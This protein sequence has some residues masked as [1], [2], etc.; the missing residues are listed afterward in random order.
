MKF[1]E[2]PGISRAFRQLPRLHA[3]RLDLGDTISLGESFNRRAPRSRPFRC[4]DQQRR[5]RPFRTRRNFFRR[6]PCR[7]SFKQSSSRNR[8]LPARL[9]LDADTRQRTHH[10]CHIAGL[11]VCRFH[12]WPPTT[13]R[14]PRWLRSPCRCN[15]SSKDRTFASSICSP[16]D[17]CTDF[18]DAIARTDGGDPR[19]TG[20]SRAGLAR[21][22]P[23]HESRAQA[24]IGRARIAKV[25]DAANP[26]PRVTV[27]DSF[28][29]IVAPFIFR[30]LPQ[31][32]R[33]WGLKKYYG[34]PADDHRRGHS[35]G[36]NRFASPRLGGYDCKTAHPN[37]GPSA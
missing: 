23:K 7:I 19:Y 10:Q 18:N 13:P 30:F 14:K 35:H 17:I 29:S 37:R 2:H 27:G 11:A 1:G 20:T 21:G 5:Q 8:A 22:R 31:R 4:R 3:V 12:S 24:R 16:A 6:K 26:P 9:G 15:S 25:I 34:L 32:V 33:I 28:Q 36:G